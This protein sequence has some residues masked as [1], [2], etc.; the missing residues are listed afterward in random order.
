MTTSIS[1]V[2]AG[3]SS[4]SES[5]LKKSTLSSN[6]KAKLEAYGLRLLME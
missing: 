1:S 6:T 5:I 3:S 2:S 4:A